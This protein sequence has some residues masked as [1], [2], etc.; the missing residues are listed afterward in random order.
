M[1]KK[2][3]KKKKSLLRKY[4]LVILDESSFEERFSLML[5]RFNVFLGVGTTAI[6]LIVGTILLIAY[7]SLK[8]YIP[9]YASTELRR[10]AINLDFKTDSLIRHTSFQETFIKRVQS[11]LNGD[12]DYDTLGS[13]K[14]EKS[15]V[16]NNSSLASMSPSEEEISLREELNKNE[17]LAKKSTAIDMDFHLPLEGRLILKQNIPRRRFGIVIQSASSQNILSV[18]EG[19][20]LSVEGTPSLGYVIF[21]QH[22]NGALSRYATLSSSYKKPGDYIKKGG[23]LGQIFDAPEDNTPEGDFQYWLNGESLDLQK[24]L[25]L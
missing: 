14:T 21:I 16:E 8:E 5:S 19:T 12:L 11:V 18:K 25:G 13:A 20:V 17:G 2:T 22:E 6:V 15:F 7:S 3:E 23:V 24:L 1:E 9:G 10:S 4:R